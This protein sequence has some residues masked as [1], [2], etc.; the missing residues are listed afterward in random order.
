VL[1]AFRLLVANRVAADD[2]VA[3]SC[4]RA[5]NYFWL[6]HDAGTAYTY[7]SYA[8]KTMAIAA[9]ELDLRYAFALPKLLADPE[10]WTAIYRGFSA[11]VAPL[12]HKGLLVE[13]PGRPGGVETVFL[14]RDDGAFTFAVVNVG[15]PRDRLPL[16]IT[17]DE[18]AAGSRAALLDPADGHVV[19]GLESSEHGGR[20]EL[21]VPALPERSVAVVRLAAR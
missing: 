19:A 16:E 18:A 7:R 5:L 2:V 21:E 14:S 20:M 13:P 6:A 4:A 3:A 9:G 11:W 10:N 8:V 12:G 1:S 17:L 15:A